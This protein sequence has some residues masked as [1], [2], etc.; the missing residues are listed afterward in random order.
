MTYTEAI[1]GVVKAV[2]AVGAGG[3]GPRWTRSVRRVPARRCRSCDTRRIVRAPS[4]Q[5]RTSHPAER[6][7]GDALPLD[8]ASLIRGLTRG[9][10]SLTVTRADGRA[11]AELTSGAS[12]HFRRPGRATQRKPMWLIPVSTICGRRAAGRYR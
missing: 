9:T 11:D 2:E 6:M 1:E 12:I 8:P 5:P 10:A 7:S 4:S 3:H